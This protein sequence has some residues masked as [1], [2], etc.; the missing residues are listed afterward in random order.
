MFRILLA[1]IGAAAVG[2][3]SAGS[4]TVTPVNAGNFADA[5]RTPWERDATVAALTRHLQALGARHLPADQVLKVELLDVDLAGTLHHSATAGRE[6]RILR[7]SA[8]VPRF[9]LRYTLESAGQPPQSGEESLSD[10]D[11]GHGSIRRLDSQP[12]QYEKQLLDRWFKARFVE[13]RAA[14]G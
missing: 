4:V 8:D 9:H 1:A 7:G 11:Y 3:A 6:L 12:L 5:G 2:T 13:R 14:P 10:L